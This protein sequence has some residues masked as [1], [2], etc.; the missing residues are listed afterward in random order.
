MFKDD[1]SGVVIPASKP[2]DVERA[3]LE[4]KN[5]GVE[6]SMELTTTSWGKMAVFRDMDGNE[7]EIS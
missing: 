6:F 5:K 2:E 1:K 3:Y 4:L 7:I